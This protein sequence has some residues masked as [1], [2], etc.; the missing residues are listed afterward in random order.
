[1]QDRAMIRRFTILGFALALAGCAQGPRPL[2][3][4]IASAPRPSVPRPAV[5]IPQT[6][7]A[8]EPVD[9]INLP[10][11]NLRGLLGQPHFVRQDGGTEMWRYDGASCRAFF[12]LQGPDGSETVRHVETLPAGAASAADPLCLNALRAAAARKPTT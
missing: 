2:A 3:P 5:P 1:M 10:P 6:P 9:F 8:G 11:A 4:V 7:P 12:F